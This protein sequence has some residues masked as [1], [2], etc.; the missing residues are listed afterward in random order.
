[1][2][3]NRKCYVSLLNNI[4]TSKKY[5][6]LR[7][8]SGTVLFICCFD[9]CDSK[10][11]WDHCEANTNYFKIYLLIVILNYCYWQSLSQL[12]YQLVK[13][14]LILC[15]Y[16][17]AVILC[18]LLDGM[19]ISPVKTQ[20]L[21]HDFWAVWAHEGRMNTKYSE[22]KCF[23]VIGPIFF[24]SFTSLVYRNPYVHRSNT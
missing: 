1:M 16:F 10:Q 12:T 7:T 13:Q 18:Y 22:E 2:Y 8:E 21:E 9:F 5:L 19:E 24:N 6:M 15:P 4:D 11:N 17:I 20:P 23:K 3:N 14:L